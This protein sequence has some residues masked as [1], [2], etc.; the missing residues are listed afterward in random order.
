MNADELLYNG[1]PVCNLK[2]CRSSDSIS[3][4]LDNETIILDFC[5]GIYSSLDPVATTIW[6]CLAQPC[7][8][9]QIVERIT[10][11]YDVEEKQCCLDLLV[12]LKELQNNGLTCITHN[13]ETD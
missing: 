12:F 1:Q 5:K 3:T 2:F 4:E 7:T 13:E 11:E 10:A 9:Q 8:F 6:D